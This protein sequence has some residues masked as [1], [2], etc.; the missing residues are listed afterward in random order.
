MYAKE[1]LPDGS[2]KKCKLTRGCYYA[3]GGINFAKQ[4]SDKWP[5]P[6]ETEN[7]ECSK[8]NPKTASGAKIDACI[9]TPVSSY[10]RQWELR[11]EKKRAQ[12]RFTVYGKKRKVLDWF[13]QSM[14]KNGERKPIFVYGAG[15]RRGE[16]PLQWEGI[17]FCS[18]EVHEDVRQVL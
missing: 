2:F 17:A 3:N 10:A 14:H 13:L 6:L 16:V 1:N 9:A 15:V 5:K 7:A 12:Q 11:F 18:H 4:H 8:H